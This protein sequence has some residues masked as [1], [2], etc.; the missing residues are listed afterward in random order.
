MESMTRGLGWRFMDMGRRVERAMHQT[1]LIRIGLPRVSIESRSALEALLEVADSIMTYRSRY[2][3]A[4]Q[5]APVLDLLLADETNPKSLAFQLSQLASH[6]ENLPGRSARR[7]AAPEERLALEMLTEV[8]LLDLTDVADRGGRAP[9]TELA[10]FLA[11]MES[12]LIQF[13]Q[14]ISAHYL[15]RVPATPHF[16]M[17]P[18]GREP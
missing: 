5:L 3:T 10:G 16:A 7:F 9:H 2:R 4:F 8:R 12:R 18:D 1:R 14:E 6:V 17:G 13:A 11:N 15:S